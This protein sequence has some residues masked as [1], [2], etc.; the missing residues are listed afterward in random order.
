MVIVVVGGLLFR[1][2]QSR[3]GPAAITVTPSRVERTAE[4]ETHTGV[5]VRVET[6]R[7]DADRAQTRMAGYIENIGNVDL[8]YVTVK[9]IWKDRDGGL[10]TTDTLY[11]LNDAILEP[12]ARKPFEDISERSGVA[13][14]N[15]EALDWW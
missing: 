9:S 14:C 7:R 12:G 11:A 1:A 13:R 8:H 6:C 2:W 10:I 4:V 3:P 5:R 15:A